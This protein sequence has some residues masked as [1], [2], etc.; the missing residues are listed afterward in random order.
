MY[1]TEGIVLKR[2]DAGEA[3]QLFSVYT[4]EYGKI[5]ARAQ[6]VKKETAKLKGHLEPLSRAH[7]GF[8]IGK[9]GER[10]THAVLADFWPAIR[11]DFAREAAARYIAELFDEQCFPG[12]SDPA[13]WKLLLESLEDLAIKPLGESPQDIRAA[14]SAFTAQFEIRFLDLLGYNGEKDIRTLQT[15]V[16]N[17]FHRSLA[18][19]PLKFFNGQT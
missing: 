12:E 1:S 9:S 10:L 13:L 16:V 17:P 6:G 3:D 4:K 15:R 7:I 8:V 14:I 11:R 2:V 5:R 19:K 18:F